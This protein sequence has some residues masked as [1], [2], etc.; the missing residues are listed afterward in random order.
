VRRRF[1]GGPEIDVFDGD[2]RTIENNGDTSEA[3]VPSECG[4]E[5]D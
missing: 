4:E 2:N 5:L 3:L 1:D